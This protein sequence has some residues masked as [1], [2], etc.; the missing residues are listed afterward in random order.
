MDYRVPL[1]GYL[2][3]QKLFG[4]RGGSVEWD[5]NVIY[6]GGYI[7]QVAAL[8]LALVGGPVL[9]GEMNTGNRTQ[10]MGK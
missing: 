7:T 6:R 9:A 1:V 5:I 10:E 3:S 2:V 8:G 4:G